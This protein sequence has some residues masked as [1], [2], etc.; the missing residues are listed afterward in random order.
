MEFPPVCQQV[1][2]VFCDKPRCVR[3]IA[4][5]HSKDEPNPLRSAVRGKLDYHLAV[6]VKDVD[7]RWRVLSRRRTYRNS[8]SAFPKYGRH[9]EYNL[10]V[11]LWQLSLANGSPTGVRERRERWP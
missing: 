6:R 4:Q 7:V 11:G 3:D 8:K 2:G 10:S 9:G 1:F 5:P